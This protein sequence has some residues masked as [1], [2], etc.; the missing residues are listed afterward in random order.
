MNS[1]LRGVCV[2][3]GGKGLCICACVQFVGRVTKFVFEI[4]SEPGIA[5][6]SCRDVCFLSFHGITAWLSP[7]PPRGTVAPVV[8]LPLSPTTTTTTR[9]PGVP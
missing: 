9:L 5:K 8:V 3:M 7:P 1:L 4:V 2:C 6:S